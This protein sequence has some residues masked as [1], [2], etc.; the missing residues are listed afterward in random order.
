MHQTLL[1][2]MPHR[3]SAEGWGCMQCSVLPLLAKKHCSFYQRRCHLL[4]AAKCAVPGMHLPHITVHP[5]V[6]CTATT[7]KMTSSKKLWQL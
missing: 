1:L 4:C 3:R 6:A 2:I 5:S 7:G